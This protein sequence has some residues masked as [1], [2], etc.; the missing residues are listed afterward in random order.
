MI[1]LN[2]QE[3]KTHFFVFQGNLFP[4]GRNYF[5]ELLEKSLNHYRYWQERENAK[6]I[7]NSIEFYST[8]GGTGSGFSV[9]LGEAL[10]DYVYQ[11]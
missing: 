6:P 10:A 8:N 5:P 3:K 1:K 9:S 2:A 4:R 7:T 11:K